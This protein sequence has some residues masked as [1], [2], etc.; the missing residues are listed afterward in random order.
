MLNALKKGEKEI[1]PT[2]ITKKDFL[3]FASS[4]TDLK[5]KD[6]YHYIKIGL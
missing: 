4:E 5:T 1:S 6:F 3:L 2:T